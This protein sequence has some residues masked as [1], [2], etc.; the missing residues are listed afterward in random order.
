MSVIL[1]VL[2]GVCVAILVATNAKL[3]EFVG[4]SLLASSVSFMLGSL[5][6]GVLTLL[7]K[8][9]ILPPSAI[10]DEPF[11]VWLG[12]VLGAFGIAMSIVLFLR[13]GAVQVAIL[14]IFGQLLA[15]VLIDT[16]G[17]LNITPKPLSLSVIFALILVFAGIFIAVGLKKSDANSQGGILWQIL[18]VSVGVSTAT[19]MA[20][21][22]QL[23]RVLASS[24]HA[25]FISFFMGA[26][27]LFLIVIFK[28]GKISR[29]KN[30]F[31]VGRPYWILIGGILGGAYVFG[32]AFLSPVLGTSKV[33][34]LAL[35]GQILM[36]V[37]IDKFGLFGTSKK[38]VT[39]T[40]IFGILVMFIGVVLLKG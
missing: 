3:K 40:S 23:S 21:N 9:T 28:D 32:G 2:M 19:Q 15:G 38:A 14:P 18:A 12:G 27:L 4:S 7:T 17:L 26:I 33:V 1:A 34:V 10:L 24:I 13:L 6:L 39:L 25:A 35:L 31:G 30:A 8:G 11:W 29:I 36:G 20:I 16:F 22:A 37:L 5:F